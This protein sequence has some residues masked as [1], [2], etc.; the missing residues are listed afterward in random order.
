MSGRLSECR[1]CSGRAK[2]MSCAHVR[3][4]MNCIQIGQSDSFGDHKSHSCRRAAHT[5]WHNRLFLL[6]AHLT[7]MHTWLVAA[8]V[9]AA[10]STPSDTSACVGRLSLCARTSARGFHGC[11]GTDHHSTVR[12]AQRPP[13]SNIPIHPPDPT[14]K[15]IARRRRRQ[16]QRRD[17]T[18]RQ[19]CPSHTHRVYAYRIPRA[20]PPSNT[21]MPLGQCV[22]RWR[23]SANRECPATNPLRL[24]SNC[25]YIS[26]MRCA[27]ASACV[28]ALD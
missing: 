19:I 10:A 23:R 8:A 17:E 13:N 15:L 22:I 14:S 12:S 26:L 11:D 20:I 18:N 5:Q 2:E 6:L 4:H 25:R 21:V 9:A 24:A 27:C 7:S 3:Q 1:S 16:R 28:C